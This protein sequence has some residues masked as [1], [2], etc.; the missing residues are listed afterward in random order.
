MALGAF[1]LT[2]CGYDIPNAFCMAAA[3]ISNLGPSPV[4]NNLGASL[5]YVSLLPVAKW[6]MM[7]LMLAGRLEIFALQA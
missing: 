4:I 5:D 2:I 1:V 7:V 6:T 3:N